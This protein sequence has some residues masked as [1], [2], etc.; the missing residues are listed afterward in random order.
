[1]RAAGVALI[2]AG[3]LG[4]ACAQDENPYQKAKVGD[5]VQYGIEQVTSSLSRWS[6]RE[7][8]SL[9]WWQK[10]TVLGKKDDEIQ[11]E[12]VATAPKPPLFVTPPFDPD[13]AWP[14][15]VPIGKFLD[16]FEARVTVAWV[17]CETCAA[18]TGAGKGKEELTVAGKKMET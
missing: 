14:R 3:V 18:R 9:Y 5:W 11:C 12:L 15:K 16:P 4:A 8:G 13:R 10:W 7:G 6:S 17:N 2:L 1:M